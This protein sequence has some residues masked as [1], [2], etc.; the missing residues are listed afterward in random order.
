MKYRKMS[1]KAFCPIALL[2]LA[3]LLSAPVAAEDR[4]PTSGS[5]AGQNMPGESV[6]HYRLG[7]GDQVSIATP[8]FEELNGRAVRIDTEGNI[9]LPIGGRIRAAGLTI[10]EL[11]QQVQVIVGKYVKEPHVA[12]SI[13][14]YRSQPVSVIGAVGSPGVRQ[15]EGV[16]TLYEVIAMA[17]GIRPE[18]GSNILITR[19]IDRGKIPLPDAKVDEGGHYSTASV[20]V[21]SVLNATAPEHNIPVESNDVISVSKAEVVYAVGSV[22]RP[23]GFPLGQSDTISALQVLSLAQGLQRTA[24]ST[25]A[26]ILRVVPNTTQREEIS[27]NLKQLL[28]GHGTDV[29]L[30]A[31]DILFVPSS[32]AKSV[33]ARS[34]DAIVTVATGIAVYGRY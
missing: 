26:R 7:S 8:E 23:G 9:T 29:S 32:N 6:F 22:N 28:A 18:A 25:K 24:A 34:M 31:D 33:S 14:E 19:R 13:V 20:S 12:I 30:R 4:S 16:K 17:G 3:S 10:S 1:M 21:A 15:L 2:S 27:V 5:T 11:E